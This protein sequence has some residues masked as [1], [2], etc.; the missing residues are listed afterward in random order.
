MNET[1]TAILKTHITT[2]VTLY[3]GEFY[4]WDVVS[5]V[6]NDDATFR[7]DVFTTPWGRATFALLLRL[8]R[9]QTQM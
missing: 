1:L 8:Q 2:E 6:L 4:A 3:K 7:T 9:L 5:E